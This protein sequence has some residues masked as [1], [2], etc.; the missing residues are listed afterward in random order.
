MRVTGALTLGLQEFSAGNS[1][2]KGQ[3]NFR[4][5]FKIHIF[6]VRKQHA[7]QGMEPLSAPGLH[8]G[9]VTAQCPSVSPAHSPHRAPLHLPFLWPSDTQQ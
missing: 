6:S 4:I 3:K 8:Q 2:V 9:A 5:S 1:I 7:D